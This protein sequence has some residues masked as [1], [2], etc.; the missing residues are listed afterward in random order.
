MIYDYRRGRKTPSK[1]FMV[2]AFQDTWAAQEEA[3]AKNE[4]RVRKLLARVD[5]LEKES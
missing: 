4:T 3:K 5:A 2:N 1:G